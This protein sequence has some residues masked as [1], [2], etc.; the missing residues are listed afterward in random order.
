M[1]KFMGS[2]FWIRVFFGYLIAFSFL[3]LSISLP[4]GFTGFWSGY[5]GWSVVLT[6]FVS[7]LDKETKDALKK[8]ALAKNTHSSD[9]AGE[10][11]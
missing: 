4:F 5:V 2:L 7:G 6:L 3:A 10:E 9:H 8:W 11:N 1:K